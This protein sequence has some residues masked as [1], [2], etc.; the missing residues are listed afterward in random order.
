MHIGEIIRQKMEERGHTVSW[1]AQQYGCS[2][3]N[4]YKIFNKHSIDTQTLMRLSILLDFDF[5]EL[6]GQEYQQRRQKACS[7]K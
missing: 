4:M 5:F 7:T 3:V 6:Y 1:L 2:R